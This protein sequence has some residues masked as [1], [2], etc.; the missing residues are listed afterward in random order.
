LAQPGIDQSVLGSSISIQPKVVAKPGMKK[1]SK[2][3]LKGIGK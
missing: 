2:P 3:E 1:K